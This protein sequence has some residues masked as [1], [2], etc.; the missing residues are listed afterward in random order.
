MRNLCACMLLVL[1]ALV[2][3]SNECFGQEVVAL[4]NAPD[5][6]VGSPF[7]ASFSSSSS[8]SVGAAIMP[9]RKPVAEQKPSFTRTDWALV[10]AGATL[11]FLDYKSTVKMMSAPMNFREVQLPQALVHN[12]PAFGAFEASMVVGDY[13]AY[14]LLVD[15][16]HRKL[17]RLGQTANLAVMGATVGWNYHQLNEFWPKENLFHE[18][19][20]VKR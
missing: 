20:A 2:L 12:R 10:S 11:R 4:L 19:Y 8:S 6:T 1:F 7:N 3:S 17:A 5:P 16:R 18:D 15:H 9:V 13:I 14:R